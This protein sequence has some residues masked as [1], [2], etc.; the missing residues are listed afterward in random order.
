MLTLDHFM[1]ETQIKHTCTLIVIEISLLT[2][3]ASHQSLSDNRI[4]A[5]MTRAAFYYDRQLFV[6]L[7]TFFSSSFFSFIFTYLQTKEIQNQVLFTIFRQRR[8]FL[9]LFRVNLLS[10]MLSNNIQYNNKDQSYSFM[11]FSVQNHFMDHIHLKLSV[12]SLT[13]VWQLQQVISSSV[14]LVVTL[15]IFLSMKFEIRENTR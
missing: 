8:S 14:M 2:T 1:V 13:T 10:F 7:F 6:L 5:I 15:N 12:N 4:Y 3:C 11:Y 9:H